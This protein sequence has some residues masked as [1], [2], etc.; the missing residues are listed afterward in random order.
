MIVDRF[1]GIAGALANEIP[2][3]RERFLNAD[4]P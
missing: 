2:T 1:A 3:I 4:Y